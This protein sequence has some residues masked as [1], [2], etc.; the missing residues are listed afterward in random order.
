M[1]GL[2]HSRFSIIAASFHLAASIAALSCTTLAA[3][4]SGLVGHWKLSGDCRDYSGH[5]NHGA[6]HGIDLDSSTFDGIEAY[7]EVPN[8]KSLEIGT[9][10]FAICANVYTED[11]PDDVIGDVIDKYD[12][13]QRCG[14]TLTVGHRPPGDSKSHHSA[15]RHSSRS[16][17]LY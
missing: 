17:A 10:D 14:V 5:S 8:S 15:G 1:R 4:D 3:N 12:P 16:A 6:N 2:R 13:S 9:G 11:D 7:I